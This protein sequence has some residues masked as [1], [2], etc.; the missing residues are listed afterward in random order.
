MTTKA[1]S[2]K[3]C[4]ACQ[5]NTPLAT[6]Q[7]I[8]EFM[9]QLPYWEITELDGVQQLRR[10]FTF[11]NFNEALSFTNKVGDIAN[12]EDH[13]PTIVTEWGKV[14]VSWWNHKI[15]GLHIND[16]IMAAKTDAILK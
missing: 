16:F 3:S 2:T 1:L 6:P 7:E 13:H 9:L 11:N 4:E 8:D 10:T 5:I 12:R 14:T 15:K